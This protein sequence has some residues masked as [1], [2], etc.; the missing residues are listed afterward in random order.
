MSLHAL[1]VEPGVTLPDWR[2]ADQVLL[3]RA[4]GE[5]A[6]RWPGLLRVTSWV[7]ETSPRP[8]WHL[9]GL[10]VD[11]GMALMRHDDRDALTG[12]VA[13]VCREWERELGARVLQFQPET[14]GQVFVTQRGEHVRATGHCLHVEIDRGD[15]LSRIELARSG[16]WRRRK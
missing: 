3:A 15:L 1:R 8:S 9:V 11:F 5:I 12:I 13:H 10:A 16:L 4:V 14:A 7:R 6:M 2:D